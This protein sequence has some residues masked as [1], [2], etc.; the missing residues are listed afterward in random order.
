VEIDIRGLTNGNSLTATLKM[1]ILSYSRDTSVP[2]DLRPRLAR[3]SGIVVK[4]RAFGD[5]YTQRVLHATRDS[6][7]P[8]IITLTILR[9]ESAILIEDR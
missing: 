8:S 9:A 6:P 1:G 2:A 7:S 3:L 4:I 5:V